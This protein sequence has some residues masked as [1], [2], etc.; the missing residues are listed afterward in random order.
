MIIIRNSIQTFP[1]LSNVVSDTLV[2]LDVYKYVLGMELKN[3]LQR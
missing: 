2:L 3:L 1:S